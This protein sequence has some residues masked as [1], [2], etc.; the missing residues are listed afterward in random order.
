[1]PSPEISPTLHFDV[2][3]IG[4]GISGNY[5]AYLLAGKGISCVVIE[6]KK[7]FE[8]RPLQCAGILS[9]KLLDLVQFPTSI[10]QN[11]VKIADIVSPNGQ[12]LLMRGKESPLV[13]D[14]IA[15]DTYFGHQAQARGA[16]YYF[17]E[18]YLKHWAKTDGTALVQTNHRYINTNLVVGADG[19]SS[20]VATQMKMKIPTLP[21]AQV[22]ATFKYDHSTTA[23]IFD[24]RW[25]ELFGYIVPEG[26]NGICR[27]GVA[28]TQAPGKALKILLSRLKIPSEHIIS[29]QGGLIPF[30]YPTNIAFRNTV[31]LGDSGC[32]V[33]ATTGGG[34]IMLLSAAQILA[35]AIEK[36]LSKGDFSLR[37]LQKHY[38]RPFKRKL[39]VQLKV[40]YLIRLV[41]MTLTPTDFSTF[42]A[43]YQSD[44]KLS[45]LISNY[46]D[47][48]FPVRVVL[49][50]FLNRKFVAFL[51][52]I[53]MRNLQLLGKFLQMLVR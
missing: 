50:L 32:M 23:M 2:V 21:A 52:P 53:L 30:G 26:S 9:Q 48:D 43:L 40:H 35:P 13:I 29:H 46:A 7:S 10:I 25:M 16:V 12:H 1:M 6:T 28:T 42:F 33:K 3:I 18:K 15:F 17:E 4:G 20:K 11:R 34:I 41:L 37:Y 22:R 39:G 5:L 19:P 49:R 38:Q 44:S 36:A 24:P 47:M 45:A 8:T 31:L 51:I 27:I 14:R